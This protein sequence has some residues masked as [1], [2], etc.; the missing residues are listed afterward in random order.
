MTDKNEYTAKLIADEMPHSPYRYGAR[1]LSR[2]SVAE[3]WTKAAIRHALGCRRVSRLDVTP[4]VKM[5]LSNMAMTE[6]G[7]IK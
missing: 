6:L 2:F 4:T 7:R 3:R 5:H 1:A